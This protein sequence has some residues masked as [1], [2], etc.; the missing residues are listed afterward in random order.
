MFSFKITNTWLNYTRF[1]G[2][3]FFGMKMKSSRDHVSELHL[4]SIWQA[5]INWQSQMLMTK[6]KKKKKPTIEA[7]I[8]SH[9]GLQ[10]N[11]FTLKFIVFNCWYEWHVATLI[12]FSNTPISTSMFVYALALI[13]LLFYLSSNENIA[14]KNMEI[15]EANDEQNGMEWFICCHFSIYIQCEF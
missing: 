8:R 4:N 15:N 6:K 12:F 7:F 10:R 14:K 13:L 5:I 11:D 3:V 2:V 9:T 1:Y